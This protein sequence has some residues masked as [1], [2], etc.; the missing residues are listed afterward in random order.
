V[1]PYL[2]SGLFETMRQ[3]VDTYRRQGLVN[4]VD[5]ARIVRWEMVK[6][7]R[8]AR[9]DALT[10]RLFGSGRDYTYRK[11]GGELVGGDKH[12]ER[13]YSEYWTLLRGA[14]ARGAPRVD[15]LCPQ[16]GAALAVG[17]EGNCE[18]CGALIA[19]GAFDWVLGGIEQDDAYRG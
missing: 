15:K 14:Q 18:H 2:S 5:G 9:Y 8:D 7:V 17:M 10:V 3:Q 11:D 1:R 16:C 6:L 12:A 19:S 13:P 4:V